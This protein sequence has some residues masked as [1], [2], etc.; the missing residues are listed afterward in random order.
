MVPCLAVVGWGCRAPFDASRSSGELCSFGAAGF[1]FFSE[2]VCHH[3][4]IIASVA[5]G[6]QW[7]LEG[8]VE[9]KSRFWGRTIDVAPMGTVQVSPHAASSLRPPMLGN[10]S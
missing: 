2:K 1:R 5:E 7:R 8:D 9:V 6:R 10:S 4:T 3:P